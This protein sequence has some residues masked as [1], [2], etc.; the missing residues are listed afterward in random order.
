MRRG[1]QRALWGA[2]ELTMMPWSIGKGEPNGKEHSL[3][4]ILMLCDGQTEW[5]DI[6]QSNGRRRRK[7]QY[8]TFRDRPGL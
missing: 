4:D 1:Q 5:R 3:P 7:H 6:F 2:K 8:Y